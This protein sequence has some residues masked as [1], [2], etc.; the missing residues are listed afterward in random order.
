MERSGKYPRFSLDLSD[1]YRSRDMSKSI[2]LRTKVAKDSSPEHNLQKNLKKGKACDNSPVPLQR[3]G[4]SHRKK[5]L[6]R[7]KE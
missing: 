1:A 3:N 6:I 2:T 4:R 7:A 5:I